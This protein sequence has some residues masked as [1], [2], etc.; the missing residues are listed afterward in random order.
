MW[1]RL[2]YYGGRARELAREGA[3]VDAVRARLRAWRGARAFDAK[4]A[5]A[6]YAADLPDGFEA[7]R[8]VL[9]LSLPPLPARPSFSF[10]EHVGDEVLAVTTGG[11][12]LSRDRGRSFTHVRLRSHQR[13]RL[14]QMKPIG[15]DE[16]LAQALPPEAGNSRT[17]PVDVLVVAR[18]GTVRAGHP[19][20]AQRWH[21]C[22]GADSAGGTLMFAENPVNLPISEVRPLASRVWRSRDRGRSW[23]I[24]H[25]CTGAQI[26]HF[27]FL[28]ARPGAAGEWW[29]ASGDLPHES[30]LWVTRDDGESWT[31]LT[32]GLHRKVRIDGAKFDHTAFRLTDLAWHEGGIVWGSD[33]YLGMA[34]PPGARV[35]RSPDAAP[36]APALVG[37]GRWHFRNIVDIGAHLLFISQRSNRRDPPPEDRKPGVYLMAKRSGRFVHLFDLDCH[38]SPAGPGFTYSTA[39][40]AAVD[41]TFFSFRA[42]EDVFPGGHKILEWNVRLT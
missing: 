8:I 11:F 39:S 40:R 23:H 13:H 12:A 33:D 42:G 10:S 6:E 7:R 37:I 14:L 32:L 20:L 25:S 26:R 2:K 19:A 41:G 27:H 31:D 22:R 28:Q 34:D 9:K 36:L 38:P 30:R 21:G 5:S 29:L 35:F 18:D 3:L 17:A 16:Y 15:G 4:S 24:V 1:H